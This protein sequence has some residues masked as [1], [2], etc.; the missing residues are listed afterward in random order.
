[1]LLSGGVLIGGNLLLGNLAGNIDTQDLLGGARKANAGRASLDGPLNMLLLGTDRRD[2]WST[3]QSDTII[4]VHVPKEHDRAYLI[5]FQRDTLVDIPADEEANYDGGQDKLNS[6]FAYGGRRE[7]GKFSVAGGFGL[8]AATLRETTQIAFDTGAVI[9]FQGFIKI[10]D[11]L[12]GVRVCIETPKGR[13]SFKS[14]HKPYRTFHKG[15][16]HYNSHAV[17][18]YTRQRKQFDSE[19]GG[20]DFARMRHQQQVI[21]AILGQTLAKGFDEPTKLPQLAKAAGKSLLMDNTIPLP[22]LA[23]AL[24]NITP[25]NLTGIKVPVQELNSGGI[26]YQQLVDDKAGSLFQAIREDKIDGW[27]LKNPQFVNPM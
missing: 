21:K 16:Q 4:M 3:W 23:F 27:V 5:S 18:D 20:G 10:V 24:R 2:G 1:M 6:A 17:L 25:A 11:V 13:N 26:S 8:M 22:D 15:C 14:I 19:P 9:D 7:N 12:G